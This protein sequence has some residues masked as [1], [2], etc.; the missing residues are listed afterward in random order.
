MT[1]C[2]LLPWLSQNIIFILLCIVFSIDL[3]KIMLDF[4]KKKQGRV[5]F[6]PIDVDKSDSIG[7]L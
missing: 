4:V 1:L 3:K 7:F 6:D 5:F 2:L